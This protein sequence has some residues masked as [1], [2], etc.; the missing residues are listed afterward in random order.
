[1]TNR[2]NCGKFDSISESTGHSPMANLTLKRSSLEN[3]IA[4]ATRK[5]TAAQ[6]R[7]AQKSDRLVNAVPLLKKTKAKIAAFDKRMTARFG[8][9]YT[10]TRNIAIGVG[11]FFVAGQFGG[12][13]M[14]ALLAYNAAAAVDPMMK[15]AEQ[16]RQAGKVTGF[17]DFVKKHPVQSTATFLAASLGASAIACGLAGASGAKLASRAGAAALITLPEMRSL[18]ATA[19]NWAAGKASFKDIARDA[20]TVC[21]SVGAFVSGSAW[22]QESAAA[23][24]FPVDKADKTKKPETSDARRILAMKKRLDG[25][26]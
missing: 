23:P 2:Q 9:N 5:A 1:M 11:K 22:Q 7:L 26:T 25:R 15:I 24:D 6:Y 12:A 18:A 13:G 3:F 14:V 10:K 19:K 21:L 16:Q 17:F 20:A 4:A 8:K